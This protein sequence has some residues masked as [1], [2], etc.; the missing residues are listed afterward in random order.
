MVRKQCPK[1][2]K[3]VPVACKACPCGH[4]YFLTRGERHLSQSATAMEDQDEESG[5]ASTVKRRRTERIQ[6]ARALANDRLAAAAESAR[7]RQVR[8][9]SHRVSA[10]VRAGVD[11]TPVPQRRRPRRRRGRPRSRNP[12]VQLHED[13]NYGRGGDEEFVDEEEADVF[14]NVTPEASMRYSIILDEINRKIG[15]NY[16]SFD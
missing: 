3:Q 12:T 7:N 14:V 16:P 5:V 1:C 8:R 6:R 10:G 4:V 13:Q 15:N 11:D 2:D 9:R